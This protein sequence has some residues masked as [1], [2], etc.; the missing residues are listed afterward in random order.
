MRGSASRSC[1]CGSAS[2]WCACGLPSRCP[3]GSGFA[4]CAWF[5][6]A[7]YAWFCFAF[8]CVWLCFAL[9][10]VRFA[11]A[12]SAW[13]WLRDVCLVLLSD[14]CVVLLRVPVCVALLRVGVRAVCLRVVRVVLAARCVPGFT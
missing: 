3:R 2:R 12:L 11:F 4:V 13:F 6:L 5:Y 14:V 8:L 9:V 10:C 1:V 7:M